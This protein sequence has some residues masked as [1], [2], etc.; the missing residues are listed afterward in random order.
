MAKAQNR[1]MGEPAMSGA[2]AVHAWTW[3]EDL[4]ETPRVS[5]GTAVPKKG[6]VCMME[7]FLNRSGHENAA[8][9]QVAGN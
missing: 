4:S 5:V 9:V 6:C 1:M 8:V 3:T 7:S 2:K